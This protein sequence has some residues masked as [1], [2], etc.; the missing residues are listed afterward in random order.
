MELNKISSTLLI[1]SLVWIGINSTPSV[2]NERNVEI[3]GQNEV[4]IPQSEVSFTQSVLEQEIIAQ[5]NRVRTNPSA[6]ADWLAGMRQYYRDTLLRIPGRTIVL[7]KEGVSALDEAINALRQT[8][9]LPPLTVFNG[10]SMAAKDLVKEGINTERQI[11]IN[12]DKVED[13]IA[14]Y[15]IVQGKQGENISYGGSSAQDI[16]ML[17]IIDDGIASRIHRQNILDSSYNATGVACD[18]HQAFGN[19]CAITYAENY[20]DSLPLLVREGALEEGDKYLS[21]DNSLYDSH[22]FPGNAQ[23]SIT[24]TL[25]SDDFDTYLAILDSNNQVIEQNDD[26]SKQNKNSQ[27]TVTLPKNDT[28][29]IIVNSYESQSKGSYTLIVRE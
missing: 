7:T 6:Y 26:I 12:T 25:K 20:K 11:T 14:L 24:I 19:L 3:I 16:V 22:P 28:Y 21:S 2:A 8:R 5:V 18:V 29:R 27:L 23:Q 13:K 9:P 4:S 15:G 10:M 1:S 17:M